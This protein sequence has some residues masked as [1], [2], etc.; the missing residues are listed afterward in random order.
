MP[1]ASDLTKDARVVAMARCLIFVLNEV[2]NNLVIGDDN[3]ATT[4]HDWFK[5]TLDFAGFK[6]VENPPQEKPKKKGRSK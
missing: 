4:L 6:L 3:K 5:K 1:D 2:K